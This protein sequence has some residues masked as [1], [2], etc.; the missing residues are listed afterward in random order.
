MRK[1]RNLIGMPVVFRRQKI[2]R[3]IQAELSPDLKRLEGIWIDG[4]LKGTRYIAAEHLGMI[5]ENVVLSDSRGIRRRTRVRSLMRRAISTDGCRAGAVTGAD[6]D[7]LS[8]LVC[9]LELSRGFWE[10]LWFG[11]LQIRSYN[12]Q[13]PEIIVPD[14]THQTF[15]EEEK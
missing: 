14:S 2:G 6:V 11:R 13:D 4:G 1:L 9:A 15:R 5:G 10:D 3:L 12:A 7:E 8:F